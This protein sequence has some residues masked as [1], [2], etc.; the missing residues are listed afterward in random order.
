MHNMRLYASIINIFINISLIS[1]EVELLDSSHWTLLN[2]LFI[3]NIIT[4][5]HENMIV[6]CVKNFIK[7]NERLSLKWMKNAEWI[8]AVLNLWLS[9]FRIDNW[10]KQS[11]VDRLYSFLSWSQ[12]FDMWITLVS[13]DLWSCDL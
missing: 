7:K 4:Y 9:C 10:S 6:W 12:L 11:F 3:D 8:I 1:T 5:I 2:S 13:C